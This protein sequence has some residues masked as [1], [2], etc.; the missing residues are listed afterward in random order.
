MT[1]VDKIGESRSYDVKV[2]VEIYIK[3]LSAS[4]AMLAVSVLNRRALLDCLSPPLPEFPPVLL[5]APAP[6]RPDS[7]T[8]SPGSLSL[9][10]S[11]KN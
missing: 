5:P 6:S 2:L 10:N 8:P 3:I 7:L 11:A 1:G 4:T 9:L